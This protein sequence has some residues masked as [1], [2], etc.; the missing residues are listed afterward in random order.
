MDAFCSC[1]L[2]HSRGPKYSIAKTK[3]M[4]RRHAVC[5]WL[6]PAEPPNVDF[7]SFFRTGFG[8]KEMSS[9][10]TNT[11][12]LMHVSA[13]THTPTRT[14]SSPP[15]CPPLTESA[16]VEFVVNIVHCSLT[17][18]SCLLRG[19]TVMTVM[20]V[21]VRVRRESERKGDCHHSL[22]QWEHRS[23]GRRYEEAEK[24]KR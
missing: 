16:I 14:L 3:K 20:T 5:Q 9:I 21:H 19:E 2:L 18:I 13:R 8:F 15:T 24:E 1:W 11:G 22:C 10:L 6:S 17:V 12:T 7:F 4:L 23:E